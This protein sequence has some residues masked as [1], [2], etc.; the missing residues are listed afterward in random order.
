MI[1]LPFVV[2][3]LS[4]ITW[5]RATT[6]TG[7]D[8]LSQAIDCAIF[9]SLSDI[10]R[11]LQGS[12]ALPLKHPQDCFSSSKIATFPDVTEGGTLHNIVERSKVLKFTTTSDECFDDRFQGIGRLIADQLSRAYSTSVSV[13]Y[14]LPQR[15]A[16]PIVLRDGSLAPRK[17]VPIDPFEL[18]ANGDVDMVIVGFCDF[19]SVRLDS[20]VDHFRRSCSLDALDLT[21]L[22]T[23]EQNIPDIYTL[24]KMM[25]FFPQAKVITN[26][27]W[28]ARAVNNLLAMEADPIGDTDFT[29]LREKSTTY[30][31]TLASTLLTPEE[32]RYHNVHHI[33]SGVKIPTVIYTRNEN[34]KVNEKI[35]WYHSGNN[36]LRDHF[37]TLIRIE[38]LRNT[39]TGYGHLGEF[40][41]L[42]NCLEGDSEKAE[43]PTQLSSLSGTM[44]KI[45]DTGEIA[46]G[47]VPSHASPLVVAEL[48]NGK[49]TNGLF[50]DD[51]GNLVSA[52]G[53]EGTVSGIIA[54]I[55]KDLV[56]GLTINLKLQN[57][58]KIKRKVFKSVS[59]LF[60][61]LEKGEIDVTTASLPLS[62]TYQGKPARWTFRRSCSLL[63]YDLVMHVKRTPEMKILVA[64]S[65]IRDAVSELLGN[66][67]PLFLR[68]LLELSLKL[69]SRPHKL[70]F[71]TLFFLFLFLLECSSEKI[72][73]FPV[74]MEL[75]MVTLEKSATVA[76][77][78]LP[79][80]C[81]QA[82]LIQQYLQEEIVIRVLL[83]FIVSP[84]WGWFFFLFSVLCAI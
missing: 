50:F 33:P 45:A 61:A 65:S 9:S 42:G 47:Y 22:S 40:A 73:L 24:R 76:S 74:V 70:L 14:V 56:E 52:L 32:R 63:S 25:K 27:Q 81:V 6:S 31:A 5:C 54:E 3:S 19:S 59:D 72:K 66:S 46:I 44:K 4:L 49:A 78:A 62:T 82:L 39:A 53:T 43:S 20:K 67:V 55:E 75:L 69:S 29:L 38:Q 34:R 84:L 58:I 79:S 2:V 60:D 11:V 8:E 17:L 64:T 68:P 36:E 77:D 26:S 71:L 21:F 18:L 48:P 83:V 13:R 51:K 57:W 7:E 30:A 28:E 35:S 12:H 15:L 80:V 37:N 16:P 1:S 10:R 23:K 41:F